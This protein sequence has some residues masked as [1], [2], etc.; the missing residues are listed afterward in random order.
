MNLNE[1][2]ISAYGKSTSECS[3]AEIYAV[4]LKETDVMASQNTI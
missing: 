3:N 4:L 1:L 2:L